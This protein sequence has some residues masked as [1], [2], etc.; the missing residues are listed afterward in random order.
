MSITG[1]NKLSFGLLIYQCCFLLGIV[2][3]IAFLLVLN[4]HNTLTHEHEAIVNCRKQD[5]NLNFRTIFASNSNYHRSFVNCFKDLYKQ[6]G[7]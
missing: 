4:K 2:I 5:F 1:G 3:F 6:A 7:P